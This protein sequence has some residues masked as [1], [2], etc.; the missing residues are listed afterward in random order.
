MKSSLPSIYNIQRKRKEIDESTTLY[1][2][3]YGCF[4]SVKNKILFF[5]QKNKDRIL[6]NSD[7]RV[8]YPTNEVGRS[9]NFDPRIFI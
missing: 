8:Y 6:L 5:C 3:G 4:V 1:E 9:I 2:N 7:N